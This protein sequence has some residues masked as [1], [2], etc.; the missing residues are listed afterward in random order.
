MEHICST[1][2][3]AIRVSLAC[4]VGDAHRVFLLLNALQFR[5]MA[6]QLLGV[7]LDPVDEIDCLVKG[8]AFLM[9]H[10]NAEAYTFHGRCV[11]R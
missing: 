8:M 5:G 4:C 9:S 7:S 3:G 2:G 6:E 11:L 10:V 1:G